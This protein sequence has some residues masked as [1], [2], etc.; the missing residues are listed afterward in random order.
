MCLRYL[1]LVVQ[2]NCFRLPNELFSRG[3]R[4]ILTWKPSNL[5][6]CGVFWDLERLWFR[7]NHP[8]YDVAGQ[9]DHRATLKFLQLVGIFLLLWL[10]DLCRVVLEILT[11]Q[12]QKAVKRNRLNILQCQATRLKL[13]ELG[14]KL[15][16]LLFHWRET[17]LVS[18]LII[19]LI[20]LGNLLRCHLVLLY[21][22]LIM[23]LLRARCYF[24]C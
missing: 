13:S 7:A 22:L 11:W 21:Q 5:V 3:C 24:W 23:L 6:R 19:D 4:D 8:L 16:K 12:N 15:Y 10:N 17:L 9:L 1:S 18:I 14:F 20:V 2:L